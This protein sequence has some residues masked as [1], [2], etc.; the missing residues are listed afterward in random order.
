MKKLRYSLPVFCTLFIAC[1]GEQT[2][3]TENE[4]DSAELECIMPAPNQID[5]ISWILGTW[6]N[7][8]GEILT[9]E[10]WEKTNETLLSG[11]S[12]S[13]ELETGDTAFYESIEI[14]HESTG[15]VYSPI[16]K[17]QNK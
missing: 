9:T 8:S 7:E 2:N 17:D 12:Y 10:K 16:V 1:G 4:K 6:Q 11:E 13:I 15:L 14:H 5:E 3:Q